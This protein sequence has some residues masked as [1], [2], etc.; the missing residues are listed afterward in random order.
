MQ[1]T[2]PSKDSKIWTQRNDGNYVGILDGTRNID[3]SRKGVLRL[4]DRMSPIQ[5]YDAASSTFDETLAI[6]FGDFLVAGTYKYWFITTDRIYTMNTDWTSFAIDATVSSPTMSVYS[7]AVAFNGSLYASTASQLTKLTAG[8]WT[9][10][11][12]IAY[13]NTTSPHPI[14]TLFNNK[15]ATGDKN[16][17]HTVDS[18]GTVVSNVI[19]IPVDYE[20]LWLRSTADRVFIGTR[21]LKGLNAKVYEWDGSSANYSFEYEVETTRLLSGVIWKG[22]IYCF[23][24][25]GRL[26][27]FNGSGFAT[28]AQLPFYKYQENMYPEGSPIQITTQRGMITADDEILV[29][30]NPQILLK[31]SISG[32]RTYYPNALAGVWA[33]NLDSG[34][35]HKYGFTLETSGTLDYANTYNTKARALFKVPEDITISSTTTTYNSLI[36]TGY[37]TAGDGT[38]YHFAGA[39][40]RSVQNRGV[41]TLQRIDS[42]SADETWQS[43]GIKFSKVYSS[44]DKIILKYK[45]RDRNGLPFTTGNISGSDVT[46]TS[47]T[48]FTSVDTKFAN[49]LVGD[50]VTLL[51]KTGAGSSAHISTISLATG[52]YTVTLDEAIGNSSGTTSILVEPWIKLGTVTS[53]DQDKGFKVFSL[54]S[55]N[56]ARAISIKGELR[57][58]DVEV[59]EIVVSSN[60]NIKFI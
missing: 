12:I 35:Y 38:N 28:D 14:E 19:T 18:S 4:A 52:T 44:E 32:E 17:V 24:L 5:R 30:I 43:V 41:F 3:L 36:S 27:R 29:S 11:G 55:K 57:G 49:V 33:Y 13:T 56:I 8:T 48:T 53:A 54:L 25:D 59:E 39:L 60:E 22:N 26:I 37:A 31:D 50:E 9:V 15:I 20:I 40:K 23:T 1:V 34:F 58:E 16:K 10:S 46:W 6:L 7:D 45:V 21:H 51:S 42:Y 2:I 47:T